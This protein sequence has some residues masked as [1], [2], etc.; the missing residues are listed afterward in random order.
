MAT[1]KVTPTLE[2]VKELLDYD[3]ETGVFRWR[4]TY[5]GRIAGNVCGTTGPDGYINIGL[6]RKIYKAHRLAWLFMFGVWPHNHIDHKDGDRGNNRINNLRVC[7]QNQN[8]KNAR[9][10]TDNKSGF[11][12]VSR[13]AGWRKWVSQCQSD[14][15][16]IHIGY[17]DTAE[18]AALAY[19]ETVRRLHGE[20]AKVNFD[21]G[22]PI[23]SG[24]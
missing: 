11:K 6:D 18:E 22:H 19:D 7:T 8:N 14:G 2:R 3:P 20:F 13:K 24:E 9:K 15:K 16:K 12:G 21:D 4:V 23:R 17:F 1:Q 5:G 10:R